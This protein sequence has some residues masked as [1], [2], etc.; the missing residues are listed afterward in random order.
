M[1]ECTCFASRSCRR[2]RRRV[3]D[4]AEA[5]A[6]GAIHRVAEL[7]QR[8]LLVQP[9]R[10]GE[11][12]GRAQ[13]GVP[14]APTQHRAAGVGIAEGV[15][16]LPDHPHQILRPQCALAARV[17][18]CPASTVGR[19]NEAGGAPGSVGAGR[20]VSV[21]AG[22]QLGS[23][24]SAGSPIWLV[25]TR[26]GTQPL[27]HQECPQGYGRLSNPCAASCHSHLQHER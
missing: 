23:P 20:G 3:R 18:A 15:R 14:A 25:V 17:G 16:H 7:Q 2:R 6:S 21:G 5:D 13:R 4:A 27:S 19:D 24:T 26:G 12:P 9:Q 8:V 1:T 11:V 22:R 10:R